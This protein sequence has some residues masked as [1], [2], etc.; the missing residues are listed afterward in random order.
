MQYLTL[1]YSTLP[2][3]LKCLFFLAVFELAFVDCITVW[4]TVEI[5][6]L[7]Q[8]KSVHNKITKLFPKS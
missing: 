4:T 2:N 3:W 6:W 7:S 1:L 8:N 5:I